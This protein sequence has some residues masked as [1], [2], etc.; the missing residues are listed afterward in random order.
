MLDLLFIAAI[1]GFFLAS[2]AYVAGCEKL[3][4]KGN[5]S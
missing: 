5:E 4:G 3:K 1:T 2:L